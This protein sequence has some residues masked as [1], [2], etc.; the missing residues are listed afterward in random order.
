LPQSFLGRSLFTWFNPGSGTGYVFAVLNIWCL[1]LVVGIAGIVAEVSG[2]LGAGKF[3]KLFTGATLCAS[4]MT[5]YVGVGRLIVLSIRGRIA[6]GLVL[7]LLVNIVL[8]MLGTFVPLVAAGWLGGFSTL[9]YSELQV[10]N[11][12]WT[13]NDAL[14]D[15][16]WGTP[17][18]PIM[19]Y[20]AAASI[21]VINLFVAMR[22]VEQVR[23]ATPQRVLDDE[24]QLHP[25]KAP[26][27][28][29]HRSPWDDQEG[30]AAGR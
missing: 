7:P 21:F 4:Y 16:I 30:S 1:V 18:V 26:V 15:T 10:T 23:Q 3:S 13:I 27:A 11:W 12:A 9:S 17:S 25:E 2:N 28:T 20:L 24:W 19:V 22:E 5:A 29:R 6:A 8:A 14:E